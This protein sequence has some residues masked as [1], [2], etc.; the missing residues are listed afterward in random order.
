MNRV[1]RY[2]RDN[3]ETAENRQKNYEGITNTYYDLATD[4][5]ERAWGQSFHFAPRWRGESLREAILRHEYWLAL[6]L[7]LKSGMQVLDLGCGVGGPMR[8][9]ARFSG[10]GVTGINNNSYQVSRVAALNQWHRAEGCRA[11]KGDFMAMPFPDG[12]MDAAYAIEATVHAPNLTSCYQEV[13]R[14]LAPGGLFA[15]Y[16][17]CMTPEFDPTNDLHNTLKRDI[18]IGNGCPDISTTEAAVRAAHAAGLEVVQ[19]ED[20]AH[21]G[22][23]PWWEPL[24][25][26]RP[27]FSSF[28]SGPVGA[29]ITNGTLR[30]L[31]AVRAAPQGASATA[32][33]LDTG[34]KALV[35]AGRLGIFTPAYFILARR[36]LD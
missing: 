13:R 3:D 31:E 24:A 4:F 7:G 15:T 10:A 32:R 34:G 2:L 1:S 29:L 21:E 30:L 36:P 6:K 22:H 14:V 18:E 28:R 9:I 35:A 5:Y 27:S 19:V 23:A 26:T 20:R 33:V 11:V 17:W 8:N 25:P 16:E 12:S